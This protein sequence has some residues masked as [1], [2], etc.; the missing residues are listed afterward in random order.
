LDLQDFELVVAAA[1]VN[2]QQA[3]FLAGPAWSVDLVD[4]ADLLPLLPR[5]L[6]LPALEQQRLDKPYHHGLASALE[7]YQFDIDHVVAALAAHKTVAFAPWLVNSSFVVRHEPPPLLQQQPHFAASCVAEPEPFVDAVEAM[8]SDVVAVVVAAAVH[9]VDVAGVAAAAVVADVVAAAAAAAE[10]VVVVVV[11]VESD[12][13]AVFVVDNGENDAAA[14]VSGL[15]T[16]VEA[17]SVA[18]DVVSWAV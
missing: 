1:A 12:P 16:V 8:E 9:I 14:A 7:I 18:F 11:V 17:A 13:F 3:H 4:V 10:C 15:V 5:S 2:L 6:L